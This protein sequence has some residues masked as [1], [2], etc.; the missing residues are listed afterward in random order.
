[1]PDIKTA[2][3]TALKDWSKDDPTATVETTQEPPRNPPREGRFFVTTNNVSRE[4]FNYVKE[5]PG[6]SRADALAALIARGYIAGSVHALLSQM[7]KQGLIREGGTERRMVCVAQEYSPLKSSRTVAL[8]KERE[9]AAKAKPKR[10]YVRKEKPEAKKP[11]E[12]PTPA[13]TPAPA[14]QINSAWS[15]DT[16]MEHLSIK[17]A[18]ALYEELSKVF[19][20]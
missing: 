12:R 11:Q 1:M 17:Q 5:N 16:L 7:V 18:R 6:V 3:S 20:N 2:L 13:P 9:E 19:G 14:T 4:T 10:K 15:A 8:E